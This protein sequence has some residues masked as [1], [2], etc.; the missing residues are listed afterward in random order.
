[1]TTRST[2]L[3]QLIVA[4]LIADGYV[5]AAQQVSSATM[6]TPDP[7]IPRN[8]LSSL[9]HEGLALHK[10]RVNTEQM[11]RGG[12]GGSSLSA[13]VL[14]DVLEDSSEVGLMLPSAS[15]AFTTWYLTTHQAEINTC[16]FSSDGRLCATGSADQSVKLIDV[17]KVRSYERVDSN[18]KDR[19]PVVATWKDQDRARSVTEVVFHPKE[20]L[21][22]AASDDSNVCV[23]DCSR[24]SSSKRG[25]LRTHNTGLM[26]V[27][28]IDV[29]PSGD[30]LLAGSETDLVLLDLTSNQQIRYQATQSS[31]HAPPGIS[32]V[33]YSP[34]GELFATA[35][36]DGSLR[37]W[38]TVSGELAYDAP[39]L[40]GGAEVNSITWSK[41]G[42]YFL[43]SGRDGVSRLFDL[44][45]VLASSGTPSPVKEY[46]LAAV[47]SGAYSRNISTKN[48]CV[49]TFS[50]NEQLVFSTDERTNSVVVWNARTSEKVTSL[51]G[52]TSAIRWIASSPVE[53]A[54]VSCSQ[55]CRGRFWGL[56]QQ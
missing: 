50:F 6:V 17:D 14:D 4:Q 32:S 38:A 30:F 18:A 28:T 23:Y 19:H 12:A 54:F 56:P 34:T 26:S 3:Y 40:H 31:C 42:H 8:F 37:L 43:T 51:S 15:Y 10:E 45:N 5:G 39:R 33:R 55:D 21:L 1:M 20:H 2:Y 9:V 53:M 49:S 13:S 36:K 24:S 16:A 46:N 48:P 11:Q 7:S 41:T 22:F 44:R 25:R 35:G 29:H 52:H 27:R 47:S